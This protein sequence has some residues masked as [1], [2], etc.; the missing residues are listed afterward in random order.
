MKS[1]NSF[2][3]LFTLFLASQFIFQYIPIN[4]VE[5]TL[6][7]H[8]QAQP[9]RNPTVGNEFERSF[10]EPDGGRGN[11]YGTGLVPIRIPSPPNGQPFGSDPSQLTIDDST[12]FKPLTQDQI[13]AFERAAS[14]GS[15][16]TIFPRFVSDEDILNHVYSGGPDIRDDQLNFIEQRNQDRVFPTTT[17]SGQPFGSDPSQLTIDDSTRFK[18]LT[19]EQINEMNRAASE[20]D[21]AAI[22]GAAETVVPT[23]DVPERF[24]TVGNVFNPT[25]GGYEINDSFRIDTTGRF[26]TNTSA[27]QLSADDQLFNRGVDRIASGQYNQRTAFRPGSAEEIRFQEQLQ[28]RGLTYQDLYDGNYGVPPSGRPGSGSSRA[29]DGVAQSGG[30]SGEDPV[31]PYSSDE[32][33]EGGSYGDEYGY[34]EDDYNGSSTGEEY[35]HEE[36]HHQEIS[37]HHGG[38]WGGQQVY[39]PGYPYPRGGYGSILNGYGLGYLGNSGIVGAVVGEI[40]SDRDLKPYDLGNVIGSAVGDNLG[41]RILAGAVTGAL[42]NA[43]DGKDVGRGAV[44]GAIGGAAAHVDNELLGDVHRPYSYISDTAFPVA[45]G[46]ISETR[47]YYSESFSEEVFEEYI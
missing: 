10:S 34:P 7:S 41:E 5:F 37:S 18:P 38:Y 15:A 46:Q 35:H 13:E 9:S 33:V 24:G 21:R 26:S 16:E 30:Y 45:S 3:S 23:T 44:N 19:Q 11:E 39:I 47:E 43:I 36:Y 28:E 27:G 25:D 17:P 22:V 29:R 8:S 40:I 2:K 4:F 1:L 12:R 32:G 31:G 20:I 14:I 6:S 42:T